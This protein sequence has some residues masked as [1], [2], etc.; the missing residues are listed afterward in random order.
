MAPTPTL[1]LPDSYN[2]LPLTCIRASHHPASSSTVT[3]IIVVTLYR[4]K[5]YN[6]FNFDMQKEMEQ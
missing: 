3:P 6:A 5:A 2:T 4:P 1:A